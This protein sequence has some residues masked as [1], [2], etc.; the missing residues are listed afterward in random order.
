MESWI[1]SWGIMYGHLN[2]GIILPTKFTILYSLTAF[3][4]T[5]FSS[6]KWTIFLFVSQDWLTAN[7]LGDRTYIYRPRLLINLI[8]LFCEI[9][10]LY[11]FIIFYFSL[12]HNKKMLFWLEQMELDKVNRCF[13]KLK[14]NELYSMI[15]PRGSLYSELFIIVSFTL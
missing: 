13:S 6:C 3:C 5:L 12:K 11:L 2:D 14:F 15:S 8:M 7:L 1:F 4:L 10:I 9:F